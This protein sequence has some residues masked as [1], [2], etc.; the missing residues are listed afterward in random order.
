MSTS[1]SLAAQP[2]VRF[3]PTK[4]KTYRAATLGRDVVDWLAWLDLGGA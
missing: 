3:D 2:R 4:D 1:T